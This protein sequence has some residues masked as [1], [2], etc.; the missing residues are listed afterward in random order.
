MDLADRF[1]RCVQATK[2]AMGREV[3]E[4]V[5]T[6]AVYESRGIRKTQKAKTKSHEKRKSNERKRSTG[7][8]RRHNR[9]E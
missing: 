1:T 3:A 9:G 7:R 8:R 5:C 6:K 4:L 2:G